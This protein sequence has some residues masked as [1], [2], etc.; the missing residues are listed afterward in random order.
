MFKSCM[1][2]DRLE[3]KQLVSRDFLIKQ[4]LLTPKAKHRPIRLLQTAVLEDGKVTQII[5]RNPPR[6]K[7]R[8]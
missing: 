5:I 3:I 8:Q 6:E 1:L 4:R 2:I 7:N